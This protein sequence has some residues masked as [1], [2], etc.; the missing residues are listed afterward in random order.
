MIKR[1]R[2]DDIPFIKISYRLTVNL[3][4]QKFV[5]IVVFHDHQV[6][7]MEG[8]GLGQAIKG[9]RMTVPGWLGQLIFKLNGRERAQ[10]LLDDSKNVFAVFISGINL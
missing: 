1:W 8:A 3:R 4:L 5:R 10:S 6:Y 9:L 2:F 7:K